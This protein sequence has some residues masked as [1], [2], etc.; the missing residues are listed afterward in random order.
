MVCLGLCLGGV[1]HG[2]VSKTQASHLSRKA[3]ANPSGAFWYRKSGGNYA[4]VSMV[5]RQV[6]ALDEERANA[7]SLEAS[8]QKRGALTASEESLDLRTSDSNP[9]HIVYEKSA[10]DGSNNNPNIV[11]KGQTTKPNIV[12]N[13]AYNS[14]E[15]Q[16]R[17]E[18][19]SPSPMLT[20]N[21]D[22]K[23]RS[24]N[25]MEPLMVLKKIGQSV[26]ERSM[27]SQSKFH[28]SIVLKNKTA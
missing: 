9:N 22:P 20:S 1:V 19:N 21:S 17:N 4:G 28:P 8:A 6:R 26:V 10:K 11:L 15:L 14:M 13:K 24:S 18:K 27:S 23:M 7:Q 12:L 5:R 2:A 3:K 16:A 25:L